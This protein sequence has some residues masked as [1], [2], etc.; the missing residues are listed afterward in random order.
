MKM[1]TYANDTRQLCHD[2]MIFGFKTTVQSVPI[3]NKVVNSIP[4]HGEVYLI[5]F[6]SYLRQVGSFFGQD[7]TSLQVKD[8]TVKPV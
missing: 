4:T 8:N 5:K 2:Y 1:N 6:V 7:Q 3:T